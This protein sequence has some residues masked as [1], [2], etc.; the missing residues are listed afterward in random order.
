MADINDVYDLLNGTLPQIK[1]D[2]ALVKK[3]SESNQ[4]ALKGSNGDT[5]L[6]HHVSILCKDQVS[7]KK[8]VKNHD[9][10]LYKGKND[11]P[12]LMMEVGDT[13]KFKKNMN[14]LYWI[15]IGAIVVGVINIL[16]QFFSLPWTVPGG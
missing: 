9:D 14:R 6:V 8:T 16:L 11:A 5:G 3:V 13:R 7:I 4:R 2:L 1:T 12:G 15:F 10:L